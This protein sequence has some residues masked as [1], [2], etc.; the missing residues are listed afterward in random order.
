MEEIH[1]VEQRTAGRELEGVKV[2]VGLQELRHPQALGG[3]EAT[4]HAVVHVELG[5]DGDASAHPGTHRLGYAAREASPM[6]QRTA[7]LI[8]PPV[9]TRAEKGADQVVMA[10]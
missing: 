5:S 7:P 9:Q 2:A 4:A 8:A 6:R 3:V 1:R 10:E